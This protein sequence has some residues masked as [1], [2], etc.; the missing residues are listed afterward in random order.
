MNSL[1]ACLLVA[2]TWF[3][4]ADW[5]DTPDPVA[6][7]RAKK[8]GIV[9]FNGG[10][11][12]KSY[13]YYIDNN[14]YTHM[15]F[16]LMFETLIS[17]DSQTLDFVPGL[18][19]KW[20]VSDDGKEFVFVIDARAKWSDGV[21]V[22]ADDVK[23]TFEQVVHE[24]SDTGPYRAM[25]ENFEIPQVLDARTVRFRLKPGT[26][27][28][29]RDLSLCGEMYVMPKHYFEG[30]DFNKLDILNAPVTGPYYLSFIQE[31]VRSEYTR[32]KHWWRKDFP[33][34]QN[35]CNFD[36][37]VL[38]YYMTPEN[39]F[40][41]L[42]KNVIDVYPVYS[43]RVMAYET[44]GEKFQKNYIVKR[45][46][47]NHNPISYQGFAMNM[48]HW[49]FDDLRVRQAMAKLIDREM[50]NRTL[51]FNEYFLLRSFYTDIYDA[52]HPCTNPLYL[53]DFEG[54][55]K[56]LKE[57]GFEKNAE[58]KLCQNGKPFTFTFLSRS[59]GDDRFLAPFRENL[60]R[61]GIQ[62][63]ID[64][65]DFANWM[66]Q[67]DAFNFD[68]TW[69]AMGGS[70]FKNPEITWLSSE[71]DRPQSANYTGFK[72]ARVDE[73]IEAEKSMTKMSDRLA[74]YREID[75]IICEQSPYAFLWNI[76]ETRL[77]YWNRFGMPDVV[78]GKYSDESSILSYWW[79][80]ADR[81]AE[82]EQAMEDEACLPALPLRV[83]YDTIMKN[84]TSTTNTCST[85]TN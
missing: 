60:E 3:P 8:G 11:P 13:N 82:L 75:R 7:P 9:R 77:L 49:P 48:R 52:E 61:L 54:A 53:Y 83:D 32:V 40:E 50:M 24:K 45:R 43:A 44:L 20:S 2:A 47:T 67:M 51:M 62:M 22:T 56:L 5:V 17:T 38:R 31:R 6:S 55:A 30:Q 57:A 58:G 33:S 12:P 1:I 72:S 68:M 84:T 25:F 37:I 78:L 16:S 4:A 71:A 26:P 66:K 74:A 34:S 42:K 36:K 79:Y 70:V 10:Q 85:I 81:A 41:A 63:K 46:I 28:N 18:A 73:I 64:R 76:A 29:W 39:A 35:V 15:V 21:P 14:T 27:K 19:S 69:A 23:W 80:D 65:C 59:A